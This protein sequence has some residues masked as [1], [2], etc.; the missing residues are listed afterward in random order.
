VPKLVPPIVGGSDAVRQQVIR[1]FAPVIYQDVEDRSDADL[2]TRV[3]FDGNWNGLDNWEHTFLYPK[4]AYVYASLIEDTNRYFLHYG[5]FWPRDWCGGL[6]NG[7]NDFHENDMEG[8]SLVVDKRFTTAGFPFGQVVTMDTRF[9]NTLRRYRNCAPAGGYP[10][11]VKLRE[12]PSVACIPFQTGY[13]SGTTPS[14]PSRAAVYVNSQS[15][16]VRAFAAGDYP[17]PGNDGVIY[18]PTSGTPQVPAAVFSVPPTAYAIQWIDSMEVA[19][20]SLWS[21]RRN[22]TQVATNTLFQTDNDLVGPHDVY[23][24]KQF[25]CNDNCPWL[26]STRAKAPWGISGASSERVGDWHNHPAYSWTRA[27]AP[28]NNSPYFEYT[29][30]TDLCRRQHAYMHNIYWDDSP[31]LAGGSVGGGGTTCT[32]GCPKTS[33]GVG[34]PPR[35]GAEHRWDFYDLR[36]VEVLGA[37]SSALVE[38]KDEDWGYTDGRLSALRLEGKGLVRLGFSLPVEPARIDQAVIR[39]RRVRGRGAGFQAAWFADDISSGS[40]LVELA[41]H[42]VTARDWEV[43]TLDLRDRMDWKDLRRVN[44]F[45]LQVDLGSTPGAVELD[46]VI[47]AP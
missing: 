21:Q 13:G 46:F 44:R 27:W 39:A 40:P 1:F 4:R 5:L 14:P 29:C 2:F 32:T 35:H 11:Y 38:V 30:T 34:R 19:G 45:E 23:Y 28:L 20:W 26:F 10:V 7:G 9:H 17:F 47:L 8:L 18:Y 37:A 41:R 36:G 33:A 42:S 12:Q 16:A 3:T 31:Y 22:N 6:C 15:H 25:G 24:L 43:L